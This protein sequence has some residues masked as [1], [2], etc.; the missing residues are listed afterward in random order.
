MRPA[1]WLTLALVSGFA[2]QAAARVVIDVALGDNVSCITKEDLID[3][4]RAGKMS[5]A[6]LSGPAAKLSA[7]IEAKTKSGKC[8]VVRRGQMALIAPEWQNAVDVYSGIS[9]M[10]TKSGQRFY[11]NGWNWQYVGEAPNFVEP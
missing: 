2:R 4:M 9:L 5:G 7:I 3:V 6:D 10:A 11:S 1:I 8:F